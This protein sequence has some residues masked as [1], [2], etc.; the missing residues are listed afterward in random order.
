MNSKINIIVLCGLG[1]CTV[2]SE[3]AHILRFSFA[4]FLQPPPPPPN[5][6]GEFHSQVRFMDSVQ[7]LLQGSPSRGETF[8]ARGKGSLGSRDDV[9]SVRSLSSR[10]LLEESF[11]STFASYWRA[12]L[13]GSV[14][15][16]SAS[17]THSVT[18][19]FAL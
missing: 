8:Q 11:L 5:S 14:L 12:F 16:L 10:L 1:H 17:P 18:T 9:L 3:T 6:L 15:I 4:S 19:R 7:S 2:A 13:G